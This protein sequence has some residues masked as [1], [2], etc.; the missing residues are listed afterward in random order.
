MSLNRSTI[1]VTSE[2]SAPHPCALCFDAA[3]PVDSLE[4]DGML[5][6]SRRCAA[7]VGVTFGSSRARLVAGDIKLADEYPRG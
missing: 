3:S 7:A 2:T 5:G 1:A 6:F 4:F